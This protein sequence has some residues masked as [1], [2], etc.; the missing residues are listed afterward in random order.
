MIVGKQADL[1]EVTKS[2][3]TT[4]AEKQKLL[5]ERIT[6]TQEVNTLQDRLDSME[7]LNKLHEAKIAEQKNHI[8]KLLPERKEVTV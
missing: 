1:T 3:D 4:E 5:A 6:L 8:E 7:S 2:R